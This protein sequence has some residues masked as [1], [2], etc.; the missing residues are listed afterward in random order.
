MA[1]VIGMVPN[2]RGDAFNAFPFFLTP[3]CSLHLTMR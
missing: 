2:G 3:K 1:S